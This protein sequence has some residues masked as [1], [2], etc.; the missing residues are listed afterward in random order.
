MIIYAN[1]Y[2]NP[3][4]HD[5]TNGMDVHTPWEA[6]NQDYIYE[7]ILYRHRLLLQANGESAQIWRKKVSGTRCDNPACGA[8][9]NYRQDPTSN[10]PR[11]LGTGWIGGYDYWGET[12]VR[13]APAMRQFSITDQGLMRAHTPRTWTYLEPRLRERD[14]LIMFD[15][16]TWNA[17]KIVAE[18]EVVRRVDIHPDFDSLSSA[19]PTRILQISNK[20]NSPADYQGEMDYVLSNGGVLWR[21]SKRPGDL[22]SYFVTYMISETYYIR[23]QVDKVTTPMW[24]GK[25]THQE[26]DIT[27][28]DVTHPA[29]QIQMLTPDFTRQQY[30]FPYS[31]F[32]ERD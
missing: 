27:E 4:L 26:M 31:E 21:T 22:D 8:F 5:A 1:K 11:C 32:Y 24:R 25:P 23:F 20:A 13:V 3:L 6:E 18:E 7:Q 12:L 2:K 15:R 17:D 19:E 10:C 30:P 28:L 9:N 14:I 29:H 16:P